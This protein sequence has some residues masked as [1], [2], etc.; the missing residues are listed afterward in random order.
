MR[1]SVCIDQHHRQRRRSMIRFCEDDWGP[2]RLPPDSGNASRFGPSSLLA[3]SGLAHAPTRMAQK[4]VNQTS[5][6]EIRPVTSPVIPFCPLCCYSSILI[7]HDSSKYLFLTYS[8]ASGMRRTSSPRDQESRW[9]AN[10]SR[11]LKSA[12]TT[13]GEFPSA[14]I[15][16]VAYQSRNR[17]FHRHRSPIY[18]C[19]RLC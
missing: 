9:S 12:S 16:T 7:H 14:V 18:T 3:T 2:V 17:S 10:R 4:I 13:A 15:S 5:G 6:H 8:L 19:K 11:S 1:V